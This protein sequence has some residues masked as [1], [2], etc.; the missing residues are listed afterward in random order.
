MTDAPEAP[1]AR[2]LGA[3]QVRE[4]A[5]RLGVRPTKQWGQNFVV[6]GNTVR[7]IVR[8]SGVGPQDVVV[9]VEVGVS[10]LNHDVG[11]GSTVKRIVARSTAKF[12]PAAA[13]TKDDIGSGITVERIR[14]GTA[15]NH[16]VAFATVD[17]VV[18]VLSVQD[19]VAGIP[20]DDIAGS[21]TTTQ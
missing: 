11:S 3:T 14:S 1:D 5:A 7:R 19:V 18:A 13:L 6:D 8:A 10:N 12:I 15:A 4:V 17:R 16:V 21:G 2:L 20:V 9:E